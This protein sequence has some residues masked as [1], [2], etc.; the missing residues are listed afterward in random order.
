MEVAV[1]E[2]KDT[3]EAEVPAEE[4]TL[5][6]CVETEVTVLPDDVE[7]VDKLPEDKEEDSREDGEDPDTPAEEL[8]DENDDDDSDD[9]E[10]DWTEDPE[11]NAVAN[12]TVD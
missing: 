12:E 8:D 11:V 9:V 5:G 1:G 10:R 7:S 2:A 3:D 4:E 6:D